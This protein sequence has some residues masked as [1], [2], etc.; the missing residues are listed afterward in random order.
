MLHGHVCEHRR[1]QISKRSLQTLELVTVSLGDSAMFM[2][3]W[4]LIGP[5][6]WTQKIQ[7]IK[8]SWQESGIRKRK[9]PPSLPETVG[10]WWV[11]H[12]PW[13]W[14]E[15][16]SRGRA[17]RA[18]VQLSVPACRCAPASG[19]AILHV[20]QTSGGQHAPPL[21]DRLSPLPSS[22]P[23]WQVCLHWHFMTLLQNSVDSCET[24]W[25]IFLQQLPRGKTDQWVTS[26]ANPCCCL[27]RAFLIV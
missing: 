17:P 26:Y 22:G 21:G 27:R 4:K 12:A 19:G 7:Q 1:I 24:R 14:L 10:P 13:A 11:V 5:K 3:P 8:R 16:G 23:W 18:R 20:W 6:S 15:P 25:G 2:G 9:S